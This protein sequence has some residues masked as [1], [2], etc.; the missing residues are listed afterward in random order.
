MKYFSGFCFNDEKELFSDFVEESDFSIAG[1][2]Y[3]AIKALQYTLHSQKRVDK[4]ILLSPAFF[5]NK[6]EKFKK[7]QLLFFKKD[8]QSYIQ[9]FVKNTLF[10]SQKNLQNYIH[11]GCYSELKEL[12]YYDWQ[13]LKKLHKDIK[14]EIHL[15]AKDKIVDTKDACEFFKEYGECFFYK[16]YGHLLC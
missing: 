15:G 12:L 7:M 13:D 3:G 1:F 5:L 14:V 6:D 2:S 8:P 4:L 11:T 10:P 9:N 16:N